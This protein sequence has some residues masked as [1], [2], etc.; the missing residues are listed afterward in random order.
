MKNVI[1]FLILIFFCAP[2][3][4]VPG[5]K[6]G[7]NDNVLPYDDSASTAYM[8]ML[9]DKYHKKYQGPSRTYIDADGVEC[10]ESIS[11]APMGS[12]DREVLSP[13][14]EWLGKH[15]IDYNKKVRP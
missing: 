7:M 15:P 14:Y 2:A 13:Y 3:F 1:L 8:N 11:T 9:Q 6:E 10:T 5:W 4:A 12:Y